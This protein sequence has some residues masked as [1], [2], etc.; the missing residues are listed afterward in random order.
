MAAAQT[1]KQML[2]QLR[3]YVCDDSNGLQAQSASTVRITV[4]HSN[5][6]ASFPELRIDRHMTIGSLKDKIRGHCGTAVSS[7]V[8][9][10][11]DQA[12]RNICLLDDD[13]KMIGFYSPQ[14]GFI[15]HVDDT[16]PYSLSANGGLENV[17]LVEKYQISDEDYMKRDDN[18][19]K[20]KQDK[21]AADPNWT[22]EKELHKNDPDWK[23]KEHVTD[24]D[25]MADLVAAMTVGD[26]CE[27]SGGRRGEVAYIGKVA[28]LGCGNWVGVRCDEPVGKNDGS[29]KGVRYF[30]C[31]MKYGVMIR[32]NLVA[33]GDY[34][35]EDLFSDSDDEI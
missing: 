22:L 8:C 7:M 5:L 34:P 23:P 21:V 30:D 15:V 25:Y 16:D 35:E 32:P 11:K 27:V 26:R 13:S 28:E 33:V 29:V 9:T 24:E 17:A 6:L 3:S 14:D 4:T 10:L 19:R 2:D 31:E 20:W 1:G 12:G 18:Y